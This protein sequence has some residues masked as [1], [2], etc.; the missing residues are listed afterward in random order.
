MFARGERGLLVGQL[1]LDRVL[2]VWFLLLDMILY[3][4]VLENAVQFCENC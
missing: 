4:T 1:W 3:K 2:F